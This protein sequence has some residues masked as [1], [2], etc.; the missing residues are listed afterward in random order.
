MIPEG[1]RS[2]FGFGFIRPRGGKLYVRQVLPAGSKR[3]VF[4]VHKKGIGQPVWYSGGKDLMGNEVEE[5]T[6]AGPAAEQTAWLEEGD[7]LLTVGVS[8]DINTRP[9]TTFKQSDPFTISAFE[10]TRMGL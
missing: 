6:G 10:E 7:Y 2:G 4:L 3:Y 8:N 5:M 9:S 1:V